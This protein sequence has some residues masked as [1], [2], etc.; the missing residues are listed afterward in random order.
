MN[1]K[2]D[3]IVPEYDLKFVEHRA[4]PFPVA[5]GGWRDQ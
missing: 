2:S 1:F 5:V 4:P 3:P